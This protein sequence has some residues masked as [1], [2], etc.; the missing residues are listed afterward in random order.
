MEN[1]E[2]K[3]LNN[4]LSTDPNSEIDI[5]D[6]MSRF[7]EKRQKYHEAKTKT[8]PSKFE[9]LTHFNSIHDL[10]EDLI[11]TLQSWGYRLSLFNIDN[12]E[13]DLITIKKQMLE[14]YNYLTTQ[15]KPID[16]LSSELL[17]EEANYTKKFQ[18]QSRF[19]LCF[20]KTN[21]EDINLNKIFEKLFSHFMHRNL[22][23]MSICLLFLLLRMKDDQRWKEEFYSK[24]IKFLKKAFKS[25]QKKFSDK[26]KD[27]NEG[28]FILET[29]DFADDWVFGD[30]AYT[31]SNLLNSF[32]QF[33]CT[34]L[35]I[36]LLID[37]NIGNIILNNLI[38]VFE[39]FNQK[40]E[41][42]QN[43]DR[44]LHLSYLEGINSI[45]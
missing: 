10:N 33:I 29:E 32:V 22:D 1:E 43:E 2:N 26:Q 30:K 16:K 38:S 12:S 4:Q 6:L 21:S 24:L 28:E 31:F 7:L 9:D 23:E 27:D 13:T 44:E 3:N 35:Q 40:L 45:E 25:F 19:L 39:T 15:M 8:K 18:I 34:C 37:A 20:G 17:K 36:D 41:N 42:D 5:I 11:Q 14:F